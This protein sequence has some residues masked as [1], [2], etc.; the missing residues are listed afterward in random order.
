MS[1]DQKISLC[2]EEKG[3]LFFQFQVYSLSLHLQ[4]LNVGP[5]NP[6]KD[7]LLVPPP[8]SCHK[9]R[10]KANMSLSTKKLYLKLIPGIKVSNVSQDVLKS[11]T[12]VA[13]RFCPPMS[14]KEQIVTASLLSH[15]DNRTQTLFS[16]D[17][18][19]F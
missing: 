6:R 3:N 7:S 11:I 1:T 17:G 13:G 2:V 10:Q 18:E 8:H 9:I 4:K 12:G 19:Y 16:G 15:E 14:N 5:L